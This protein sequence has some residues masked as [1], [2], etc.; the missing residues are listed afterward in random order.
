[1]GEIIK[2]VRLSNEERLDDSQ[3]EVVESILNLDDNEALMVVGPPGTGK[4]RVIARASE[5]LMNR[6]KRILIASHTNRAVDNVLERL[7]VKDS[8]RVGR[9]EKV[10]DSIKPYLLS[11]KAETA[12]GSTL[13]GINARIGELRN[14]IKSLYSIR[15][16]LN[17]VYPS[18]YTDK[19]RRYKSELK[20]LYETR[21][22]MLIE[23][24]ELLVHEAKIIGSTLIR[25]QLPPLDK[26]VFDIIFIDECSQ[27]SITLALLGMIKA[28]RWVL[29]GDHKQLLPIF[30]S[31]NDQRYRKVSEMLSA[32][33]HMKDRYE[34]RTLW[35]R[36]HYRSNNEIIG[37]S[38][39]YIYEGKIKPV[40]SCKEKKLNMT[41][42]PPDM[43]FLNPNLLIV[44]IHID[45]REDVENGG[46]RSN[47]AEVNAIVKIV[48][49]LIE[50]GV[51]SSEIGVITP[52]RAQRNKIREALSSKE[53][54]EVNTVD[55]F[56]GREKDVIIFSI[57]S[58]EDL[59]FV[60]D[61]NRLNVAF[62]RAKKKLI[63]I[64]NINS[65]KRE[66]Q[67]RSLPLLSNF[68]EYVEKRKGLFIL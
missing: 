60:E 50:H 57:T 35:L 65:I 66:E 49:A 15:D 23:E 42:Y 22:R 13:K 2:K 51:N 47:Y 20:N 62:T 48:Y 44:F 38:Q 33:C 7:P 1:M 24:S 39:I 11:Y 31:L 25:S 45:G 16:E 8:L 43:E 61:E 58:T 55:S 63:V 32:F 46:S 21:N 27:A 14:T 26:E 17:R 56:Q 10:L 30:T 54:I 12:L 52:Y 40:E 41:D 36:Y 37:F 3:L 67:R 19:I 29:V 5:L 59:T 6:G 9:P 4:T 18:Q 28:K 34:H 53:E 64:G 68:L